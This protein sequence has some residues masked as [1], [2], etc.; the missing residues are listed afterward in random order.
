MKHPL[1]A[2]PP[3]KP[4]CKEIAGATAEPMMHFI[5]I[6]AKFSKIVKL[7]LRQNASA[8]N[9]NTNSKINE[10]QHN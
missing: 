3:T 2:H 1:R 7:H 8:T 4:A 10:E 6:S 5:K 9:K